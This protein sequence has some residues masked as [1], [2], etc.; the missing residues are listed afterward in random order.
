MNK[1]PFEV[2]NEK[3][4]FNNEISKNNTQENNINFGISLNQTNDKEFL[5]NCSKER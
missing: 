5:S 4:S 1:L 2:K 3:L